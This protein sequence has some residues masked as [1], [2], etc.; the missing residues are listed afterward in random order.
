MEHLFLSTSQKRLYDLLNLADKFQQLPA[1]Q[2]KM[3]DKISLVV[4]VVLLAASVVMVAISPLG[5]VGAVISG[6]IILSGIGFMAGSI[7]RYQGE[8][9]RAKQQLVTSVAPRQIRFLQK[10]L[11]SVH[12]HL[13]D[14]TEKLAAVDFVLSPTNLQLA[15]MLDDELKKHSD[16]YDSANYVDPHGSY[17]QNTFVELMESLRNEHAQIVEMLRARNQ[18]WDDGRVPLVEITGYEHRSKFVLNLCDRILYRAV[19]KNPLIMD[20]FPQVSKAEKIGASIALGFSLLGVVSVSIGIA[21]VAAMP[22]ALLIPVLIV[23]VALS[24]YLS[25]KVISMLKSSRSRSMRALVKNL[26]VMALQELLQSEREVLKIFIEFLQAES[27]ISIPSDVKHASEIEPKLNTC[28]NLMETMYQTHFKI[29]D[30]VQKVNSS[31]KELV[32]PQFIS[33]QDRE[34]YN[35]CVILQRIINAPSDQWIDE[36]AALTALRW[37]MEQYQETEFVITESELRLRLGNQ[38]AFR[39]YYA[40][41]FDA[42]SRFVAEQNDML[43]SKSLLRKVMQPDFHTG[44]EG[45]VDVLAIGDALQQTLS[46]YML[47][48]RVQ[49]QKTHDE[50]KK[51]L[52]VDLVTT[53]KLK[54]T[55]LSDD[56]EYLLQ[57]LFQS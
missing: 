21:M 53:T 18:K 29:L 48:L 52:G 16:S 51:T 27:H 36:E 30:I 5:I 6:A 38:Q 50:V 8:R 55:S 26:N 44:P 54:I 56:I 12:E 23:S 14:I 7:L 3:L 42:L 17:Q 20:I 25:H 15:A 19:A 4:G 9:K 31:L 11:P 32:T 41:V 28:Y 2:A 47:G 40:P 33:Q 35:Q 1:H 39:K 10:N 57:R 22:L 24:A 37:L 13:K 43:D 46:E 45:T 49:L 34:G